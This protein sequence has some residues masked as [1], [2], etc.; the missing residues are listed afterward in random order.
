MF[1]ESCKR[2]IHM[3]WASLRVCC[4]GMFLY[5]ASCLLYLLPCI[6]FIYCF[7]HGL[8]AVLYCFYM[9]LHV[10]F[11]CYLLY[12]YWFE[13]SVWIFKL[14]KWWYAH[15]Q[16]DV[17]QVYFGWFN[18]PYQLNIWVYQL[19]SWELYLFKLTC[20]YIS[21]VNSEFNRNYIFI[22]RVKLTPI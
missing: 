17:A 20:L 6:I 12:Y 13:C 15:I 11:I 18:R 1:C 16:K 10:C 4:L 7:L 22:F 9:M 3:L 21:K 2:A 14:S 8:F 5:A 19:N